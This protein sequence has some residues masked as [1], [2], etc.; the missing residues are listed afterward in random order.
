MF[1]PEQVSVINGLKGTQESNR[2]K[3]NNNKVIKQSPS[4][5]IRDTHNNIQG[6]HPGEGREEDVDTPDF[7]QL[8]PGLG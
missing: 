5:S 1:A 2:E 4:S 6:P 7:N 3:A 8:K